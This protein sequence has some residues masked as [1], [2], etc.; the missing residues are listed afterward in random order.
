MRLIGSLSPERPADPDH[1]LR[2]LTLIRPDALNSQMLPEEQP[3]PLP[4]RIHPDTASRAGLF[5]GAPVR[6]ASPVGELE[7]VLELDPEL[8]PEVVASPRGGWLGLG[9]GVN[10]ATEIRATDQGHG[11]AYYATEVRLE[12]V[13][14]GT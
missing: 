11:A 4:V 13:S 14:E 12:K 7:G 10:E 2:F 8:H 3:R 5:A 1:P 6:L 9:L